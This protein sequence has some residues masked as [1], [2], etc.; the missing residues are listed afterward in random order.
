V[1]PGLI[2]V[3][4]AFLC[5]TFKD[6]DEIYMEV[7]EG[8]ET[9]FYPVDVLLLLLLQTT[10]RGLRQARLQEHFGGNSEEHLDIMTYL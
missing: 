9:L 10:I 3:Q 1:C 6:G 4:G 7:T 8:F 5:G 2:D